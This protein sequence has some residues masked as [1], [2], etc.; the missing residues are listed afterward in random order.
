MYILDIKGAADSAKIFES[1]KPALEDYF[2]G[3]IYSVENHDSQFAKILDYKCGIDAIV[4]TDEFVF[5]I[6]HRVTYKNYRTFTVRMHR[7]NSKYTEF[8]HISRSGIKPR[9]H[10]TTICIDNKPTAIAIIKTA[11]LVY[12]INHNMHTLK[13][14]DNVQFA[15]ISWDTLIKNGIKIDIIKL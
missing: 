10:V 9:Y 7:Q 4:D 1:V 15:I 6:A 5:G 12:A 11:D 14:Y 13:S 2:N 3:D 8:D